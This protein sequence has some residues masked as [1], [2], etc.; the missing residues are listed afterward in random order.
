M[1]RSLIEEWQDVMDQ[2]GPFASLEQLR[3]GLAA[4]PAEI[5]NTPEYKWLEGLV[6]GRAIFE[7]F[8]G[9]AGFAQLT[10]GNSSHRV[11]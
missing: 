9:V 2:M 4:A 11:V 8:G 6:A 7:E 1:E 3:L 5:L 10:T